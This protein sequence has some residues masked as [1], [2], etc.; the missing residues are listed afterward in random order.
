MYIYNVVRASISPL[1][2]HASYSAIHNMKF[3]ILTKTQPS[4][5]NQYF[6]T[7]LPSKF[8]ILLHILDSPLPA[9]YLFHSFKFDLVCSILLSE[10]QADAACKFWEQ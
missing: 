3:N 4:Q 8:Q 7:I 5:R 10:G 6:V 2:T 9:L 1:Y